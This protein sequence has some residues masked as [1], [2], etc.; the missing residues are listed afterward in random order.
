MKR[1]VAISSTVAVAAWMAIWGRG[2]TGLATSVLLHWPLIPILLF[3]FTDNL[4]GGLAAALVASLNVVML[5]ALG[6]VPSW[7]LVLWQVLVYAVFGLYPF[8]FMQIR[9]QRRLHYTTLIEYKKGEISSLQKKVT[10]ID[11]KCSE[12][13]QKVRL[14]SA[15]KVAR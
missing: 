8:K 12:I 9:E 5:G 1:S 15:G 4:K 6:V 14:W 11:R 7:T 3:G 13:D 10:E 2:T